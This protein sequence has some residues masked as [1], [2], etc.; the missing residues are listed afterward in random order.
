MELKL[1]PIDRIGKV[2]STAFLMNYCWTTRHV[3]EEIQQNS[4]IMANNNAQPLTTNEVYYPSNNTWKER[5]PMPTASEH[6]GSAIV[7]GKLYAIGGS[8]THPSTNLN[9]TEVY[10]PAKTLGALR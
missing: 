7:D 5:A 10:D 2:K 4:V 8:L 3:G 1:M 9:V 6:L